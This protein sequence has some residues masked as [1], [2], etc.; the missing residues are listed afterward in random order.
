[1]KLARMLYNIVFSLF[2]IGCGGGGGGSAPA[3]TTFT[4]RIVNNSNL[5]VTEAFLSPSSAPDWG[6]D[7]L[8]SD[9]QLGSA[10]DIINVPCGTYDYL[11]TN[12][13][14]TVKWGPTYGI[15]MPCGGIFTWTLLP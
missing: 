14:G 15:G 3:P 13:P 10:R 8:S 6:P 9:L 12:S 5:I 11:A 1:M 7:Q 4:F 2:L